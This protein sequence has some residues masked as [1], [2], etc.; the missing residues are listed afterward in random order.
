MKTR[1]VWL[2]LL[3]LVA[4][5]DDPVDPPDTRDA[6][7]ARDAGTRDGGFR[8]GGVELPLGPGCEY[9]GYRGS[10]FDTSAT[11]VEFGEVVPDFTVTTIR[12]DFTLSEEWGDCEIFTLVPIRAFTPGSLDGLLDGSAPNNTYLF[13]SFAS[14]PVATVEAFAVSLNG[15][16]TDRGPEFLAEWGPKFRYVTSPAADVPVLAH[17]IGV[18]TD[19]FVIDPSQRLRDAGSARVLLTGD[20]R[21]YAEM[22]KYAAPWFDYERRLEERLATEAADPNV[23]VVPWVRTG[24]DETDEG[25][26]PIELPSADEMARFDRMEIVVKETCEPGSRFPVHFG[27]CPAW[28]VGHK[29][30]YCDDFDTCASDELNQFFR[31]ITGY[32][33]GVWL[34]QDVSFALPWFR[35][36]GTR[37]LRTN[38]RDFFGTIELR[39]YDDSEVPMTE[40]LGDSVHLIG[41]GTGNFDQAHN[42]NNTNYE[43]RPPP[44][45]VRVVMDARVQG[46]GN[47]QPSGCAEFCSHSHT[48]SINDQSFEHTF[49][50]QRG[51]Q[52]AARAGEGVTAGQFGTW[53]IDRGSWCPG[54]HVERWTEDITAAVDLEDWN[55]FT[56]VDDF[57]GET[58]LP[59]GGLTATVW[60][61]FFG[62]DGTVEVR[63][64]PRPQCA[65]PPQVIVR[66]FSSS[67][68]DFD[69]MKAAYDALPDGNADK[70]RARGL[71]T[72]VVSQQLV[73]GK[74]QLVW[75]AN[76]LPYTS[77]TSFASWWTDTSTSQTVSIRDGAFHRTAQ[78]THAFLRSGR[79][80]YT[81]VPLFEPSQGF[82]PEGTAPTVE[83]QE[84]PVN[85][86]FTVEIVGSF[87]HRANLRLRVGSRSDYFVYIDGN[88][89]YETGGFLNRGFEKAVLELDDLGLT[90]GQTY[91]LR[92]FAA[93]RDTGG[94]P[95]MWFEHPACD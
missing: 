74:P 51:F 37:W 8:D 43:F 48:A 89:V 66:D 85:R 58:W 52:C 77:T 10:P 56:W 93:H 84:R 35:Q 63:E 61:Q 47:R 95:G 17:T 65:H 88:L 67:H 92:V 90:V 4:C 73:N 26:L 76:T 15:L 94:N 91:D 27:V 1:V 25:R 28:D 6:G 9:A 41:M 57:E 20:F 16:L 7:T 81:N 33:S 87:E 24:W 30:T 21:P 13:Y 59:G 32:H 55:T 2:P 38:R 80:H 46:G 72:G 78:G 31:Y 3:L 44:G 86:S 45:T 29:I 60:L 82:G 14:D 34:T 64:L 36:G 42:E 49:E 62:A 23:L 68:P 5:G 71:L 79:P 11:G 39:F 75:P 12:G 22:V 18:N 50:M 40:R 19:Y 70:E 54:G 53:Y 69:P 83:G